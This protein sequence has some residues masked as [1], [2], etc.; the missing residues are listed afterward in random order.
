MSGAPLYVA[1]G[2]LVG[3]LIGLTGVGGGSLM[4]PLL[5]LLF[6]QSPTVAV[7]TDLVFAAATKLAAT[8][9]FGFSRRV[10]WR[11][12]GRLLVGSLPGSGAVIAWMWWTRGTPGAADH[13]ISRW[14]ALL[15]A[16]TSIGLLLQRPLGR[17]S[18]EISEQWL[19]RAERLRPALAIALGAL[20]GVFIALTSVGAGAL[21][22]VVLFALYPRRLK[23]DR[24]VATDIAHALPITVIAGAGHAVLGHVDGGILAALLLGS[25]PGVLIAS[26]LSL[27]M[28][29][30][31]VRTLLAV[32]LGVV[33][34][35]LLFS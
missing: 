18:V 16:A 4:T 7:G 24:L 15:L 25:I 5:V 31:L 23:G 8:A 2:F 21:G 17:I 34:E 22:V 13:V 26:R 35:R 30:A 32:V 1:A 20:L 6:G 10:D 29:E 9:S 14:L 33:S 19:A 12:V 27:R 28:P 3:S 11:I